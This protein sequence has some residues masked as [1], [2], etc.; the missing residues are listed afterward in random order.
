VTNGR[1]VIAPLVLGLAIA[2]SLSLAPR[3][4][5]AGSD[6]SDPARTLTIGI[7][8]FPS[9]LHPSIGATLAKTY[10]HGFTRRPITAY[11]ADWRQICIVC[12]KIP[13]LAN[14]MAEREKL[15]NG[16][17]GIAVTYRLQPEATWGDGEPVTSADVKFTWQVGKH[18][19]S[20]VAAGEIYRRIRDIEI[21]GP[22]KF[23]VHIDRV[24]FD[25]NDFALPIL[26]EHLE[27]EVFEDDPTQYRHRTTFDRNST[28]PGLYFGPYVMADVTTGVRA[29]FER[30]PTWF[31]ERPYFDRIVVRVI[32]NTAALEANLLSGAIDMIAG[33]LGLRLHQAIALK[34]RRG[35]RF[36]FKFK[37]GLIYEHIEFNLDDPVLANRNVRRALAY[38][39][40]RQAITDV[41]FDGE[42]PVAHTNV[43]PLDRVFTDDVRQ[44]AHNP[45]KARKLLREAGW[46]APENGAIRT[47]ADG[48]KLRFSLMTTAGERTRQLV[49]QVLQS[50]WR[51]IG[52]DIRI[53][54]EPARVF[55]GQ[56]VT[57][58]QF[59]HMAMFAWISSPE[60]VPRATL[61][62]DMIPSEDNAWSGQNVKGYANPEVD[63][64]IDDMERELDEAKRARMWQR[65][66]GIYADDLPA[67]PLYWRAQA[68]VLPT[69][70]KGVT[71]T[72]HQF[73]TSMWVED[74]RREAR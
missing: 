65:L 58:R 15:P 16:D 63:Q 57:R 74:W 47:N 30:N 28:N 41:L 20:G 37:P 9:T 24:T 39:A 35:D 21:H 5:P 69:W 66:Q 3:L 27:R 68:H 42:Q 36:R 31:G 7:T 18:P 38:G 14:G 72:G 55:F 48:E 26:P 23:T 59:P 43:S 71:P 52:V 50:Q 19:K 67:L 8:Q 70:L 22:K 11:N 44:Y 46:T 51:E 45:D 73:P 12:R 34:K 1:V 10:L 49:Q 60:S 61:H 62:S 40:N 32:E 17:T 64:L 53:D 33:E 2:A 25:Y 13:T 4:S 56:T 29:V 54:N 6:D